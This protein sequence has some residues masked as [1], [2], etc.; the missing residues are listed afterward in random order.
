MQTKRAA[1]LEEVARLVQAIVLIQSLSAR[2]LVGIVVQTGDRCPAEERTARHASVAMQ[3]K[4]EVLCAIPEK[5]AQ[6]S[7]FQAPAASP[8]A[9]WVR[10]SSTNLSVHVWP[11]FAQQASTTHCFLKRSNGG[12]GRQLSDS[13]KI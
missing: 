1:H 12:K 9:R 4:D 13:A 7:N 6:L 3:N 2:D 10:Q 8:H 5:S 11:T